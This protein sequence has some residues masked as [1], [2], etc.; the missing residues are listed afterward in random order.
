MS[1]TS[2]VLRD[3]GGLRAFIENKANK[4]EFHRIEVE[5]ALRLAN[6]K[7][8]EIQQVLKNGFE[9]NISQL[10]DISYQL[11]NLNTTIT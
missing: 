1:R 8:D 9:A 2:L 7:Q 10:E 3:C 11:D 4:F 6:L 5:H